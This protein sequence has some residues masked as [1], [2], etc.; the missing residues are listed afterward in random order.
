MAF[1]PHLH[2][3]LTDRDPKLTKKKNRTTT[4][5]I[6][7]YKPHEIKYDLCK[8]DIL[9]IV[10]AL[11]MFYNVQVYTENKC[12]YLLHIYNKN[13]P[14]P[15]NISFVLSQCQKWGSTPIF[16]GCNFQ[17]SETIAVKLCILLYKCICNKF[18]WV[19]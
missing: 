10:N 7:I 18:S 12:M 8:F 4:G 13:T 11:D 1:I 3:T 17:T 15:S 6:A 14:N 19:I 5:C 2:V 16:S 9:R